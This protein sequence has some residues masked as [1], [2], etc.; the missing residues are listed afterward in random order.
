MQKKQN[1]ILMPQDYKAQNVDLNGCY[2]NNFINT[3]LFAHPNDK[4]NI[5]G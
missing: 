1:N 2:V 3:D 4:A 5:T